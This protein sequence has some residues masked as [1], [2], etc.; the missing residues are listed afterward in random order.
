MQYDMVFKQ[1]LTLEATMKDATFMTNTT[2]LC[3]LTASC[4]VNMCRSND[5]LLLPVKDRSVMS[6]FMKLL[7]EHILADILDWLEFVGKVAPQNLDGVP[8]ASLTAL[9][10]M[11]VVL[12]KSH[13]LIKS[14]HVRAKVIS[15]LPFFT[16][17]FLASFHPSTLPSCHASFHAFTLPSLTSLHFLPSPALLFPSFPSLHLPSFLP[18]FFTY[19]SWG[20]WSST[21]AYP[22]TECDK[23]SRAP[24]RRSWRSSSS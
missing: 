2:R 14:P 1:R 22:P 23:C 4:I 24:D 3:C 20:R 19:S 16:P 11:M 21:F 13:V 7:P 5:E 10:D 12:L 8:L 6:A 18:S 15:F 17:S 9:F